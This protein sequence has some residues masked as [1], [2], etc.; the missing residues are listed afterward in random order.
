[1]SVEF[2]TLDE[3]HKAIVVANDIAKK[4][5]M[6]L[7]IILAPADAEFVVLDLY[8]I[9]RVSEHAPRFPEAYFESE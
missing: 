9:V 7:D 4:V 6:G 1:M 8:L 5:D 2:L 3:A